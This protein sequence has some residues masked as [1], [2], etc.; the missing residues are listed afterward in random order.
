MHTIIWGATDPTFT[1][2]SGFWVYRNVQM[3]R[4]RGNDKFVL[5]HS[6]KKTE[7]AK[8]HRGLVPVY[9]TMTAGTAKKAKETR[10]PLSQRYV[11]T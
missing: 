5:F 10:F 7:V 9:P 6:K 8:S 11:G 3:P 4:W 2:I 1:V